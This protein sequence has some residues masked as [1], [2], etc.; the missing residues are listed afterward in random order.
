MEIE[1]CHPAQSRADT[2]R[3][4]FVK[5]FLGVSDAFAVSFVGRELGFKPDEYVMDIIVGEL[6][7]IIRREDLASS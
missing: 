6:I 3:I 4:Q 2:P 5:D 7:K 1:A